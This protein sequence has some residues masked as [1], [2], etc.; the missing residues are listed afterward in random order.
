VSGPLDVRVSDADRDAACAVLREHCVAG[1]LTLDEFA[2]RTDRALGARTRQDLDLVEADLPQDRAAVAHK[3]ARRWSV[4]IVG[5]ITRSGRWLVPQ[6]MRVLGL[7]G[8][9]ELDLT[10]ALIENEVTTI[11]IWLLMGGAE[12]T[13]PEGIEVDVRGFT[14]IGGTDN[15][16]G[17]H[18]FPGAPRIVVRQFALIGG[19]HV[20]MRRSQ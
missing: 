3:T 9:A 18:A 13:V 12:V 2:E 14:V 4:I 16:A 8:G 17:G 1:R 7:I 15:E 5:G 6:R 11:D 10:E 19:M 20:G